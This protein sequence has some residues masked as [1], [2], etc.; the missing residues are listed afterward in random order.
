MIELGQTVGNYRVTAK[1]GEGG[2]GAVYLAEHPIIGRR[3]ALKVIHPQHARDTDVV[4]RFV[5]EATAINRIGNEHIVEVTDFG[6]TPV[7]DFYFI[8][9]HLEGRPLNEVIAAQAPFRPHQ[10]VHIATQIADAL[11][12]SHAHGV[13]HR[14]LKPDNIFLVP[15][16]G[17]AAFVKVL[18]FGLA[19]L[20]HDDGAPTKT[21]VGI[22]M[23][24]P[25]YMSPEQCEGGAV[26][27]RSDVYSLGVVLFEMLTG[28][29]PFSGEDPAE[30][31]V[32]QVTA[33]VPSARAIVPDLPAALDTIL[34]R[35]LAKHP[36]D[37][38]PSMAAFKK[39]LLSP[40][41]VTPVIDIDAVDTVPTLD[42]IPRHRAPRAIAGIAL[43]ALTSFGLAAGLTFAQAYRRTA[44]SPVPAVAAT[45]PAAEQVTV[46]FGSDPA[47]ATVT[48]AAGA[49]LGTT[50]LVIEVPRTNVSVD[51]ALAKPGFQRRALSVIPNVPSTVFAAMQEEDE[52]IDPA[53]PELTPDDDPPLARRM[54][55][56][57]RSGRH[58]RV[59]FQST[60]M[61]DDEDTDGVLAPS[62]VK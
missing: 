45:A 15:R 54:A 33:R 12:A 2:M 9:E 55:S 3:A 8:M 34:R 57:S 20:M 32:K 1:I 28:Q 6:R 53:A 49:V 31:L 48:D 46:R 36:S 5:N 18:D 17:D 42:A 10:A 47:G 39:A 35:A 23:G 24:T 61:R 38:Y 52:S 60:R 14:D 22:V 59:A 62:F 50:P 51:Y 41:D 30:I 25:L 40:D 27:E 13:I 58:E 11:E 37:R 21:R 7:G 19:K 44:S 4:A 16:D 43:A 56:Q 29:L 26:D